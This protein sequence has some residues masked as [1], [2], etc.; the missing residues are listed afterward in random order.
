MPGCTHISHISYI[1]YSLID[2]D[3]FVPLDCHRLV[4][5]ILTTVDPHFFDIRQ[6]LNQNHSNLVGAFNPSEKILV[7]WDDYSQYMEHKKCSKPPTRN[8]Y[9]GSFAPKIHPLPS[10]FYHY[11]SLRIC[12]RGSKKS[13]RRCAPFFSDVPVTG[14]WI[15]GKIP[16][17]HRTKPGER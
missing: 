13:R 9:S 14:G 8:V 16:E 5:N 4:E 2:I 11:I 3:S 17:I 10:D 6:W 15:S 12:F 1:I 7:S